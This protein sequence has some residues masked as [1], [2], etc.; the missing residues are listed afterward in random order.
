[1]NFKIC[2]V[3][4]ENINV[5]QIRKN[6]SSLVPVLFGVPQGSIV[7]PLLIILFV[8]DFPLHSNQNLDLWADDSTLH[9]SSNSINELNATLCS[10]MKNIE[11][12]S[13]SNGMVVYPKKTK[14]MVIYTYQKLAKMDA[15]ELCVDSLK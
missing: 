4:L 13:T 14:S 6:T 5:V 15:S 7:G 1:M 9:S 8:N 11:Q 12:W 2:L 3:A 10:A